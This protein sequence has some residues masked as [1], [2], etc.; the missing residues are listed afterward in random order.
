[1]L[2]TLKRLIHARDG[3]FAIMFGLTLAPLMMIVGLGVDYSSYKR[4]ETRAQLSAESALLHASKE[5][6]KLRE[7]DYSEDGEYNMTNDELI[8]A[9]EAKFE[10]FFE[11]NFEAGGYT[12]D[13]NAYSVE[14]NQVDNFVNLSLSMNYDTAVWRAFGRNEL[15]INVDMRVSMKVQPENY[16]ID[17]VMCLD[18]TGSMQSTINA[19]QDAATTFNNDLRAA[20]GVGEN[21]RKLKIRVRPI[22]Y[23][24]W[25][26]AKYRGLIDADW[27]SSTKWRYRNGSW[28][29]SSSGTYRKVKAFYYATSYLPSGTSYSSYY[30]DSSFGYWVRDFYF[31]ISNS[32]GFNTWRDYWVPQGMVVYPDFIDLDPNT[33]TGLTKAGQSTILENFIGSERAQ[34]GWD[35][36]EGAGA[37]LDKAIK[38]NWYDVHSD[39]SRDYFGVPEGETIISQ[40]DDIPDEDYTK[41]SLVP[42]IVFWT[43]AAI[44]SLSLSEQWLS[45]GM[46]TS[47]SNFESL[48]DNATYIDQFYKQLMLFGTNPNSS[49][50]NYS[51][52]WSTIK[53]W[54][55]FT[56]AGDMTAGNENAVNII[57]TKILDLIPDL[58]RVAS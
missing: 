37:C 27:D 55:G 11:T 10:P 29:T 28:Q 39:E 41:I 7:Q 48:W 40:G 32:S 20:L 6:A 38:S 49:N 14:Y 18:A 4:L 12:L 36:P 13:P 31:P 23:R 46:P 15:P 30:Y 21:S 58:L 16:V 47:Y 33:D 52:G 5:L 53:N 44:N 26:D 1:M 25:D 34:G 51:G 35:W 8:A 3:N 43:D 24:D 54:D 57:A 17:I 56:Y 42:M 9:I 50:S 45:D 22:Y 2:A 19:V